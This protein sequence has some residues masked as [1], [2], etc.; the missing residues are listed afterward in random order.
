MFQRYHHAAYGTRCLIPY[1]IMGRSCQ[2]RDEATR[3]LKSDIGSWLA[4]NQAQQ[5]RGNDRVDWS[6]QTA[7][8]CATWTHPGSSRCTSPRMTSSAAARGGLSLV[9]SQV[10]GPR[11]YARRSTTRGRRSSLPTDARLP[12]NARSR[13]HIRRSRARGFDLL[14]RSSP[15][16]MDS[17]R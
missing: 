14:G 17:R 12:D 13:S 8:T 1:V 6:K 3:K 7:S 15:S 5:P 9:G 10:K 16:P 11:E 2:R 4:G